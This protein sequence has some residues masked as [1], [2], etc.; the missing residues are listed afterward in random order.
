MRTILAS[1]PGTVSRGIPSKIALPKQGSASACPPECQ[2]PECWI[3]LGVPLEAEVRSALEMRALLLGRCAPADAGS[4]PPL[5]NTLPT[6]RWPRATLLARASA[7]RQ[8][9][10]YSSSSSLSD[11]VGKPMGRW[12]RF[13]TGGQQVV[14]SMLGEEAKLA[15]AWVQRRSSLGKNRGGS[16]QRFLRHLV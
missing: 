6:A 7:V 3:R 5:A 13:S 14:R 15:V 10:R 9:H 1:G 12:Y 4:V 16:M 11:R 2:V 8:L